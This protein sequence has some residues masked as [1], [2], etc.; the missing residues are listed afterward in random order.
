MTGDRPAS[1][2]RAESAEEDPKQNPSGYV[3]RVIARARELRAGDAFEAPE[4]TVSMRISAARSKAVARAQ[5]RDW[6][7]VTLAFGV[8]G[9]LLAAFSL[10]LP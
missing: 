1:P 4:G 6:R 9:G 8:V 7:R 2:Y 3:E 10:F 5:R